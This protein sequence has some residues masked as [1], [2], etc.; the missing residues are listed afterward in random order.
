MLGFFSLFCDHTRNF[1]KYKYLSE[2]RIKILR[3]SLR[4]TGFSLCTIEYRWVHD[5]VPDL[6][7]T[8]EHLLQCEA[9]LEEFP[10]PK[11]F[12]LFHRAFCRGRELL[13]H[14]TQLVALEVLCQKY[15]SEQFQ[16]LVS[17]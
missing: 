1:K 8:A 5:G 13:T 7:R 15:Q 9:T 11:P 12:L 3:A 16:K 17:N 14:A 6:T 2:R 4:K 10:L